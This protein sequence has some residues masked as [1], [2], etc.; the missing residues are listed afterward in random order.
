LRLIE[1]VG[2]LDIN[3]QESASQILRN[4][5]TAVITT[6]NAGQVQGFAE[7]RNRLLDLGAGQ[8]LLTKEEKA[9]RLAQIN[10][11]NIAQNRKVNEIQYNQIVITNQQLREQNA[12]LGAIISV[13]QSGFSE[14]IT[15]ER[16]TRRNTAQTVQ[17]LRL[18]RA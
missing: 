8:S 13:L 7:L 5:L 16:Q 17:E 18:Q 15:E 1:N 2:L 6:G 11:A 9:E 12:K 3:K 4:A 10:N 14:S